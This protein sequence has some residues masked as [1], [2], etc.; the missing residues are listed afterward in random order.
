MHQ[1][2]ATFFNWSGVRQ[3]GSKLVLQSDGNEP[4]D[5]E[6]DTLMK[7]RIFQEIRWLRSMGKHGLTHISMSPVRA[8]LLY[9]C[10][11]TPGFDAFRKATTGVDETGGR[12]ID[13]PVFLLGKEYTLRIE[14]R[15]MGL[16]GVELRSPNALL[17]TLFRG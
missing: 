14:E 10:E 17:S 8:L 16:Y 9:L 12:F 7:G 15:L 6:H 3:L 2:Y 1:T 13:I 5:V 11:E 4:F